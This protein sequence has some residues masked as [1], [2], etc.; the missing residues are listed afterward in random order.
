MDAND[1][2]RKVGKPDFYHGDRNKL[3]DWINQM[4]L[5]FMFEN[6][7]AQRRTLF[8][9]TYLRGRAQHWIKPLLTAHLQEQEDEGEIFTNYANFITSIRTV[10]GI[11]N[12]KATAIRIIQDL[13][14]KT[15]TADYAAKFQEYSPITEWDDEAL[16]AMFKRGLKDSVKDELMR[17]GRANEDLGQLMATCIDLDDRLYERAMEKRR[18]PVNPGRSNFTPRFGNNRGRSNNDPYGPTPM[19]L[20]MTQKKRQNNNGF[21]KKRE[22]LTCYACGKPGHMARDCRSK[23]KVQRREFNMTIRKETQPT[24]VQV[25]TPKLRHDKDQVNLDMVRQATRPLQTTVEDINE[26]CDHCRYPKQRLSG[27]DQPLM[28]EA[29]MGNNSN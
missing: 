7:P 2:S 23:N 5:Y 8:A 22:P 3:D 29:V 16:M 4:N 21:G 9:T 10:F 6:V 28:T 13:R 20:D 1:L 18:Y 14:Q 24:S 17:D 19:E 15:S 26:D 12:E 11:S 25:D 27:K